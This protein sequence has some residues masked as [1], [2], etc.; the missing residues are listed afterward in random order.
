[1]RV[2]DDV[3][4]VTGRYTRKSDPL[5]HRT[6]PLVL[7]LH[8]LHPLQGKTMNNPTPVEFLEAIYLR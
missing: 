7:K 8:L 6:L 4:R 5:P 3:K 2:S 1:M